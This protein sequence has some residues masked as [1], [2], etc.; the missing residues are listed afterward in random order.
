MDELYTFTSSS[1]SYPQQNLVL[2]DDD[3]DES[4]DHM[5][6]LIK[7]QI[8]NHPLYP[9]LLSAY[10]DCTKVRTY[11]IYTCKINTQLFTILLLI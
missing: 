4:H 3:D 11:I 10:I 9:S 5:S 7:A 1:I 8:A 2:V 6:D